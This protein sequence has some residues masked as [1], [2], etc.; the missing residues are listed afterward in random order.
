MLY[1]QRKYFASRRQSYH[2]FY[3]CGHF[4]VCICTVL[5]RF[6]TLRY[7]IFASFENNRSLGAEQIVNQN[8]LTKSM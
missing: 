4:L 3:H 7:V 6:R 8:R 5:S 2:I 1:R